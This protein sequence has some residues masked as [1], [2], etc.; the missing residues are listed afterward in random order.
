MT[1]DQ[2]QLPAQEILS[3]KEF[4]EKVPPGRN[5]SVKDLSGGN[6]ARREVGSYGELFRFNLPVLELHCN[7]ASCDGIRF[8]EPAH[9]SN[10]GLGARREF[11]TFVCR[12]CKE[13]HKTY[14]LRCSLN[15][16]GVTGELFKFGEDPPFGPP[17]PARVITLIGPERGYFIKGY[18]AENQGLGIA[19]YAYYRR[20]VENQKNRIFD[21][22]IRVSEKIGAPKEVLDDLNAAKEETQFSKAIG[23]IKHGIP[24]TL[25]V[26][27]HNPLTLLHSALSEG[28]HAQTDEQCLELATSIRVVLTDLAERLGNALREHAELNT[29]VSRLLK[30]KSPIAVEPSPSG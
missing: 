18:K 4:F 24:Q 27:G 9:T 19:A 29:A 12:N 20:V 21:E 1:Q 30:A 23:V 13:T 8:F 28:L 17:I 6:L 14:A 25:L 16:D 7:T 22:I 26:N 11:V 15:Q 5:V 10:I 2:Q 3:V